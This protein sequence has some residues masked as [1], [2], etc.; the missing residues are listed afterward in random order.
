MN[1]A[2]VSQRQRKNYFTSP[3]HASSEE[4][5]GAIFIQGVGKAA[6]GGSLGASQKAAGKGAKRRAKASKKG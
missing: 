4:V 6:P 5:I 2:V 1:S 3:Q